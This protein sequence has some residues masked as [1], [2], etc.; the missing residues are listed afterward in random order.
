MR[1]LLLISLVCLVAGPVWSET[2]PNGLV[3]LHTDYG[4]DSLYAGALRGAIYTKFPQARIDTL[5]NSVPSFDIATGAYMLMEV[6]KEF[7]AGTTF[8]CVVDPGVGSDRKCVVL[9]TESGQLFVG[10]DNGLLSLVAQKYG[11][12]ELRECTNRALWREG[13]VSH[14]FHGRDIFGPVAASLA[15]GTPLEEVGDRIDTLQAIDFGEPRIEGDTISGTVV[16]VD[17]YGNMIT[18][19][20]Y[21]HLAGMGF[22]EHDVVKV[23]IGKTQFEAPLEQA[24]SAVPKGQRLGLIQS[25]GY[26]E[27]AVNLGSLSDETEEGAHAPVSVR[28]KEAK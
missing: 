17:S 3:I 11:T 4:T 28:K 12:V 20:S 27:F 25:I 23:T 7:P 19:I 6:C 5:T 14:T 18:N 21:E 1:K 13:K 24:Y 26:L 16:R 9:E 10:P 8:C 2:K 22:K 15:S